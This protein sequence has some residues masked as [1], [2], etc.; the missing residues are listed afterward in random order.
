MELRYMGFDQTQNARVYRFERM[1]SGEPTMRWVITA[2]L[3]LFL[4]HRIHIQ[5]GPALCAN[6]LASDLANGRSGEHQLTNADV[7]THAKALATAEA[8]K[9]ESRGKRHHRA[10]VKDM[11]NVHPNFNIR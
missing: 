3:A 5:D 9:N 4:E 2:D 1:V 6:K 7:V 11:Q 10:E 8:L